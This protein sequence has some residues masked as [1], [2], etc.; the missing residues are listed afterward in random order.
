[1]FNVIKKKQLFRRKN[2]REA[3]ISTVKHAGGN[4]LGCDG[5]IALGTWQLVVTNSSMNSVSY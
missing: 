3:F 5:F 1:M 4:V 2:R